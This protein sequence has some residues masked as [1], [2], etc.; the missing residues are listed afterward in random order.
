MIIINEFTEF[1]RALQRKTPKTFKIMWM[2][3]VL[4]FNTE[5]EIDIKYKAKGICIY[6]TK[7]NTLD[8]QIIID[9]KSIVK[10][11]FGEYQYEKLI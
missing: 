3:Q 9:Y 10:M 8:P 5:M 11:Q 6:N 1:I 7:I 4:E 2:Y